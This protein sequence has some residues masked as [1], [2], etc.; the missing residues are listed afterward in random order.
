MIELMQ[1][2]VSEKGDTLRQQLSSGTGVRGDLMCQ[3]VAEPAC[4]QN[5]RWCWMMDLTWTAAC[6]V[7]VFWNSKL[8]GDLDC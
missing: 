8:T 4:M 5:D 2:I 1:E 6:L 7:C 3:C